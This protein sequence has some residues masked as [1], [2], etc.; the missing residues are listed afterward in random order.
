MRV[1]SLAVAVVISVSLVAARQSRSVV[2]IVDTTVISMTAGAAPMSGQTLIIRDGRIAAL[3]PA[4]STAVPPG[5]TRIDGRG[6]FAIPGLADM[7]VHLEYFD[8]PAILKLFL[9][10]GVTTVRNMDGR[11]YILDWKRRIAAGELAGPR[12]YSG[13]P[14]LDG[15]PPI[16]S[17]NTV[18]ADADAARRAVDAQADAG[19]DFIKAYSALS[20]DAFAGIVA[21]ARERKLYVAGHVPRA[22]GLDAVFES[23][24]RS[25]EHLSDYA[26]AIE[27]DASPFKGKGHWSK[28]YLSMPLDSQRIRD[29]GARHVKAQT[30]NVPTLVQ[31]DKE[32]IDEATLTER[33]TSPELAYI[34]ADGKR[35]WEAQTRRV[36]GRMDAEDWKLVESGRRN[37]LDVV[38]GFRAA[39]VSLLAGTD[40][41]NPFVVPGFA[42][43]EELALLV[44]AG[45]TPLEA[46]ATSTRE[47]ARFSSTTEWG[48]LAAGAAADIVLLDA[49]PIERIEHTQRIFGVMRQGKWYGPDDRATLLQDARQP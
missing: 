23:G 30:W 11:P 25:I 9:A 19:Y 4:A 33:L 2:A 21:R 32:L 48:T 38:A 8:D 20:K 43:H 36:A 13:G 5:A 3:G 45:L 34:P 15:D 24:Q 14:I 16:R 46:L 12:I 27:A 1:F 10:Q 28:R 49:S 18:V 35:L 26:S 42:L 6:K 17:D 40:T 7:H 47:A 22:A 39:G 44:R 41:P 29:M 37:R 31:P